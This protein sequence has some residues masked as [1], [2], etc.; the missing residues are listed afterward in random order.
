M[1]LLAVNINDLNALRFG[2]L[3]HFFCRAINTQIQYVKAVGFQHRADNVLADVVQVIF[4]CAK[5]HFGLASGSFTGGQI[6]NITRKLDVDYI[7]TGEAA[8]FDKIVTLCN[9]ESIRKE[10]ANKKIGF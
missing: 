4:H 10:K 6:E 7:L 1:P 2:G 3:H 5:D 8:G 9:E